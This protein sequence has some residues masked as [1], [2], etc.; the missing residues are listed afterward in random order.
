MIPVRDTIPRRQAPMMTWALIAIDAAVFLYELS[1]GPGEL[2]GLFYVFGVVPARYTHLE[3]GRRV[4]FPIDDYWPFLTSM[5]LHGGWA[6]IIGNMW[7]LWIFGD[8]V[9]ERMGRIRFLLF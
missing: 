6:H 1:L 8:N 3:W 7:S 5:F 2:E 4:G 9:E